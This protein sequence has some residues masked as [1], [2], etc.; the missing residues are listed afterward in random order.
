VKDIS[1]QELFAY[2]IRLRVWCKMAFRLPMDVVQVDSRALSCFIFSG[3]CTILKTHT[4]RIMSTSE[5]NE[6]SPVA[7]K[8]ALAAKAGEGQTDLHPKCCKAHC[9]S[10]HLTYR[11]LP[12]F[13]LSALL[14]Y[15]PIG[16][17]ILTAILPRS[18]LVLN[19]LYACSFLLLFAGVGFRR[20]W[21]YK[22]IY[23]YL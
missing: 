20:C 12:G 2:I 16:C 13:S 10:F 22:F 15:Q 3:S 5:E 23:D 14:E 17:R 9:P 6:V 1:V 8:W 18:C 4:R 19:E 7:S 11:W 21:R